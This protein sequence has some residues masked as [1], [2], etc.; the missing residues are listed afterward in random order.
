V[1]TGTHVA[2]RNTAAG[3]SSSHPKIRSMDRKAA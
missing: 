2:D 3:G 1:E